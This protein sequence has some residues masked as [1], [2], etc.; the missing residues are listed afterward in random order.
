MA[1]NGAHVCILGRNRDTLAKAAAMLRG[2]SLEV[3]TDVADV[4]DRIGLRAA[5][6]RVAER[7]G[8]LDVVF[9]N[10][11]ITGG[12]GYMTM[13]GERNLEGA[14]ENIPQERWR[15]I[16]TSDFSSV[17][18]TMQAAVPHMKRQSTGGRIIVT[19]SIAALR[20]NNWV[21]TPLFAA[22][23]GAAQLVEQAAL[24]LVKHNI[25]VN[26]IA[27]G[28]FR[29]AIGSDRMADSVIRKQY[30]A[31]IPLHRIASTDE[32]KGLALYLASPASSYVTGTQMVIDGGSMTGM[33]D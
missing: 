29:T 22:K 25:L 27:P 33:A 2:R 20:T 11:G 21:G 12:A 7:H 24:E 28:A 3:T 18:F 23:A 4:T 8:R 31:G 17:L 13:A 10:A 16:I 5:I 14:V 15:S 19:T 9:A 26:A 1:E 30:E 6:D 32:I